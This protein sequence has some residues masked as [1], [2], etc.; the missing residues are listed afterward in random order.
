V[1][2]FSP[3]GLDEFVRREK[4]QTNLKAK[5]VIYRIETALQKV[6]LDEVKREF[7]LSEAQWW[8]LGI[9]K[10]VRLQ[11]TQKYE[12]D[13]GKRGVKEAYFDL[14][15]YRKIA[16]DNWQLFQ[17]LIGYGKKN[18]SK[19]RQTQW[20]CTLNDK[21][22]VVSHPSSGISLSVEEL[23]ELEAYEAWLRKSLSTSEIT[24]TEDGA[25]EGEPA[26]IEQD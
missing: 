9:P 2:D 8:I 26:S 10:Q 14:M 18:Q 13:N 20:I 11:V 23:A 5:E 3:P 16:L 24:D 1:P 21:R 12:N 7:G 6:V 4:E 25:D 19:D 22:N 17:N 15:D